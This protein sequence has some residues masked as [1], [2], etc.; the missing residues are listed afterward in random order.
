MFLYFAPFAFDMEI[1]CLDITSFL[2]TFSVQAHKIDKVKFVQDIYLGHVSKCR[3]QK[4]MSCVEEGEYM[5]V[6]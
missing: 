3:S 2:P 5:Q 6:A 1:H 4:G